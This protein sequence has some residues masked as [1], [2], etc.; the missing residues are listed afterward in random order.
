MYVAAT[1]YI[2]GIRPV[3]SGLLIDPCLPSD[4]TVIKVDRIFRGC[5]ASITIKKP[6]GICR[7]VKQITVD[8][9][10]VGG[11]VVPFEK[12]KKSIRVEVLM[13]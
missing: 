2:L 10:Q 7:G 11:N 8:G 3:W 13:G 9:K 6:K 1:Q 5:L 4:W 12:G